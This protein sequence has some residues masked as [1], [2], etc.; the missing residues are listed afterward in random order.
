VIII[1]LHGLLL[2]RTGIQIDI[3]HVD[4]V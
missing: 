4:R 1:V 2:H 3:E